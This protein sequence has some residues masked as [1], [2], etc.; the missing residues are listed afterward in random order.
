MKLHELLEGKWVVKNLDGK[1]RRFKDLKDAEAW[2][3]SSNAPRQPKEMSVSDYL[4]W[5]EKQDEKSKPSSS[6]IWERFQRAVGNYFP[7]GDPIGSMASWMNANNLTFN[8]LDA[9]VKQYTDGKGAHEYIADM[10]DDTAADAEHDAM[11]G[12]LGD[13]YDGA[14]FTQ[15]NPWK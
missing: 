15:K 6:V 2:K 3:Q 7:D 4:D 10:W 13:T 14:W 1:E 9:A 12:H 8:D 11:Q 5:A